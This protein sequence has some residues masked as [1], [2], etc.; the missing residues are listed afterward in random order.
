[1][2]VYLG[3]RSDKITVRI[4]ILSRRLGVTAKLEEQQRGMFSPLF[5]PLWKTLILRFYKFPMEAKVPKQLVDAIFI[6]LLT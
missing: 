5:G 2:S 3:C 1:M 4:H 6:R